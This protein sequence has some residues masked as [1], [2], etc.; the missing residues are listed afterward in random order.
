MKN[1]L[2]SKIE[3][4]ILDYTEG[5]THLEFHKDDLPEMIERI[6]KAN[7]EK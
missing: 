4:I 1:D 5:Y 6:I 3:D 7:T 2:E